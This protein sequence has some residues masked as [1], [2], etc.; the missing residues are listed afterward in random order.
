MDYLV[1]H[2]STATPPGPGNLTPRITAVACMLMPS[3]FS[4]EDTPLPQPDVWA[5]T[6]D[7]DGLQRLSDELDKSKYIVL[8]K[9]HVNVPILQATFPDST[10]ID[11]W[12]AKMI[13][14]YQSVLADSI[15]TTNGL[16]ETHVSLRDLL[17]SNDMPTLPHMHD[18][19]IEECTQTVLS[20][21]RFMHRPCIRYKLRMP[22]GETTNRD[23][24]WIDE[25]LHFIIPDP[26]V[27]NSSVKSRKNKP[28]LVSKRVVCVCGN[29]F[30]NA[31]GLRGHL[32]V[33]G[34]QNGQ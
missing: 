10:K 6:E 7:G 16:C 29:T 20:L 18:S 25:E 15:A 28:K 19:L 1:I 27:K 21:G 33:K 30:V 9:Q 11:K 8:F 2:L 24:T 3:P 12:S 4:L 32:M 13:D 17:F 34:C 26:E 22:T 5:V 23:M 31:S 14:V